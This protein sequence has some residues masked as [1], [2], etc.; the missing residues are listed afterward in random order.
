MTMKQIRRKLKPQ[1]HSTVLRVSPQF[2]INPQHI[3]EHVWYYEERKGLCFFVE[4]HR[5]GNYVCTDQF[6]VP[7]SKVSKSLAR[8]NEVV[9]CQ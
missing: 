3:S 7:W 1:L 5:D 9:E 6:I 8:R 2:N 4:F